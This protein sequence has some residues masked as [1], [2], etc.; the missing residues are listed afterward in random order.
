MGKLKDFPEAE[1]WIGE[2]YRVEGEL[3][4]ALSQ[5][6][7]AYELREKFEDP[8]FGTVLQYKIAGILRTMQEYNE[9]ERMLLS[10]IT[11]F[12]N[13][14]VNSGRAE[15][16]R[17]ENVNAGTPNAPLP[18]SEAS[19]SFM[20]TS[21]TRVLENDGVRRFLELYRYNNTTVEEAHRL[22]GLFY[23]VSGRPGAQQHMMFSFLIQNSIILEELKRKQ[24]DYVFTD[25]NSLSEDIQKNPI[26]LAYA[27]EVE[28]YK[29]AYYLAASLYRN[30]KTAIARDFWEFLA[31]E[32]RAGEWCGRAASQ[33]R[34][35]RPEPLVEMP[36]Y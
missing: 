18:Y 25:L 36:Q 29:T 3:P 33:L 34:N 15:I 5:Y 19:A 32:P 24:Y 14:W 28:Y 20:R 17:A 31:S 4:L 2:V 30:G 16:T 12:D 13:L 22:L 26:L 27:T 21:M 35:P 10:I 1:Y 9:M 23:A 11:G 7:K 6:R 8:G